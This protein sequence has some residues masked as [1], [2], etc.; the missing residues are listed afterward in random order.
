MINRTHV[1]RLNVW[2]HVLMKRQMFPSINHSALVYSDRSAQ[3]RLHLTRTFYGSRHWIQT[4][5]FDSASRRIFNQKPPG[6]FV[7]VYC[8]FPVDRRDTKNY[9]KSY[10]L[11]VNLILYGVL[12]GNVS[13]HTFLWPV[14]FPLFMYVSVL[15]KMHGSCHLIYPK[16]QATMRT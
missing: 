13:P 6:L 8:T 16:F 1:E 15:P 14:C 10:H 7:Y 11:E 2:I 12:G 4:C 9:S 3:M 5:W